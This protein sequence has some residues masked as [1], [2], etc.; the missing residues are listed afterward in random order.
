VETELADKERFLKGVTE[1]AEAILNY[2]EQQQEKKVLHWVSEA[3]KAIE[4]ELYDYA[5]YLQCNAMASS[6]TWEPKPF[7][8]VEKWVY[9]EME[10]VTRFVHSAA[11]SPEDKAAKMAVFVADTTRKFRTKVLLPARRTRK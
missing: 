11:E 3:Y 7:R 10:R 1:K 4:S 6:L 2:A 5:A 9:E 8:A